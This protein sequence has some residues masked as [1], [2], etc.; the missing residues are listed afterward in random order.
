[1]GHD[2]VHIHCCFYPTFPVTGDAEGAA[3]E[4]LRPQA[5][6]GRV[7]ACQVVPAVAIGPARELG[8]MYRAGLPLGA[9]CDGTG[10]GRRGGHENQPTGAARAT[11]RRNSRI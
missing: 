6:D 7:P 9:A 10:P 3:L 8:R 11:A 4:R 1:M 5:I 2:M